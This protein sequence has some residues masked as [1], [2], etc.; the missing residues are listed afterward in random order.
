MITDSCL[1]EVV[2]ERSRVDEKFGDPRL[3]LCNFYRFDERQRV[4]G[5]GGGE[6]DWKLHPGLRKCYN[7]G[8]LVLNSSA[9]YA[10]FMGSMFN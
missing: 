6:G 7:P 1:F 5:G 8:S 10:A 9:I 4:E 2:S 3:D